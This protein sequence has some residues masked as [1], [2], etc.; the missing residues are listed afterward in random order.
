MR[1]RTFNGEW[2]PST[3]DILGSNSAS[4]TT[5][6]TLPTGIGAF[7]VGFARQLFG[8]DVGDL[9]VPDVASGNLSVLDATGRRRLA[10]RVAPEPFTWAMII[11]GFTGLG[12]IG[13]SRRRGAL[14]RAT[15]NA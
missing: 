7:G 6:A 10:V 9:F 11:L 2:T 14:G 4:V 1:R 5:F 8:A 12:A 15:T 3:V 13:F